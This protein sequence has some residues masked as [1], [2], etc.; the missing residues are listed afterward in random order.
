M[1]QA[2]DRDSNTVDQGDRSDR[3]AALRRL[4]DYAEREAQAL[5]ARDCSTCLQ[6]AR[7]ALR[8]GSHYDGSRRS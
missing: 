3:L 2:A 4:L 8:T 7:V 5:D 1:M 6:L